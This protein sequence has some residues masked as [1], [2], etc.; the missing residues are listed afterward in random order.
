M[1]KDRPRGPT[2]VQSGL[3][4]KYLN[5]F[6]RFAAHNLVLGPSLNPERTKMVSR[7]L[8][9]PIHEVVHVLRMITGR[10]TLLS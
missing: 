9:P 5:A 7:A 10:G 6:A 2:E 1:K 4:I 3:H 8:A